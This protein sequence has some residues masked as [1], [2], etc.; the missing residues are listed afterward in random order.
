V[1]EAGKKK[2]YENYVIY[3]MYV[4]YVPTIG[5][6]YLP[7]FGERTRPGGV[8]YHHHHHHDVADDD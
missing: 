4:N 5:P 2:R 1:E 8:D 6:P 7:A 3:L